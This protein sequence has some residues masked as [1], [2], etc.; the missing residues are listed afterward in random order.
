[1]T[2]TM[3]KTRFNHSCDAWFRADEVSRFGN[4]IGEEAEASE[5]ESQHGAD[6]GNYIYDDEDADEGHVPGQE[7]M[8]IDGEEQSL[9]YE[10]LRPGYRCSEMR[11]KAIANSAWCDR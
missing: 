8:E 5:E 3:S 6:A 1:M 2:F 11:V 10:P 4:F 7:L 9:D